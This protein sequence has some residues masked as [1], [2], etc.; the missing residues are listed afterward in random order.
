MTQVQDILP[1]S[2]LQQGLFFHALH[3]E[4]DLYTAQ[5]TLDLDGPLDVP[6]LRAAA[7]RLLERHSNLRAAFWHEDL[8]R[9]VQVIPDSVEPSWRE[10]E[11]ADPAVVAAEERAR[12]FDLAVPPLI[13]FVLVRPEPGRHRLIIT[14]HHILLDGWSTPLLV[15]ELLA[16]YLGVEA[17]P[18]PPYKNYLAWL[19][20]QDRAAAKDAWDRALEGIDEPTLVAP[21]AG[22][23]VTPGKVAT[24]LGA[25][26][27]AALTRLARRRGVTVNTVL[28][29]VWGL[30]LAKLTGREDVV[31]GAVVS[32][33]PPELPGVEHMVG[34]FINTVPVR[35]RL[36]PAEPVGEMLERLQDEQ[37]ELMPHHHLGLTEIQRGILFDTVT[38][39]ENYPFD[40]STA[41]TA[42]GEV[43]LTGFGSTDAHHYP[44]ALAALP[45]DRLT[46]RLDHRPDLFSTAEARRLLDR[47]SLLLTAIVTDPDT[48]VGR[49]GILDVAEHR[50]AVE[51][52]NETGAPVP[53]RT[54]PE[55]FEAAVTRDPEATAL[56]HLG[57][58][59]TYGQLNGRA[60][61]L[62]RLL[63]A[64]HGIGPERLVALRLRRSADLV[65]AALA[66]LKAGG[67]YLPVDLGYPEERVAYMLAD[68]APALVIDADW[69]A[70]VDT[71]GYVESDPG[72]PLV[73]ESPAYVIYTS[74]STGRPKG[75]VVTHAGIA[76][77][78]C[79]QVDRFGITPD[80]RVLHFAS[81]SFDASVMELLMAFAAGAA[82]VIPPSGAYSG[83][84]LADALRDARVTHA[85]I[86][87]AALAGVPEVPLPDLRTL[88]V[89]GDACAPNLVDTWAPGRL[90][91]N[92][93][94]PTEATIAATM[95]APLTAGEIPPI[96]SPVRDARA[97]VLDSWLRPVPAGVEGELYLAGPGLARG[98]LGRAGLTAERFVACP[99][100]GRGGRMYRT[101][102]V[103]RRRGD[104][105]V[106]FVGRVD[107]QV[108]VR[109]FRIEPGEVEAVLARHGSVSRVVVVV[110]EDRPGD[111]RL[112]A[113]VVP[114]EGVSAE[115]VSAEGE[116]AS[117]G[118][119]PVLD[120]GELRRFAGEVLPEFMVPSAVVVLGALPVT[121][122]GKLDRAALP[123]PE[124]ISEP[125][126]GAR[127]V[128][129]E[130]LCGVFAEVLGVER[131]GVEESFF[132]LGGDSLLAMRLV[133]R[134]RSVLGVEVSVRAVFEASTVAGLA[135]WIGG[136]GGGGVR[137]RVVARAEAGVV[138]LSFGQR[139]LWFLNRLG[140]GAGVYNVPVVLRLVGGV[141]AG[142]LGVAL[143][144]VV[145]R[146]ES[147]R[148]VFPEV[149]GV[150]CQRVLDTA[151]VSFEIV[152]VGADTLGPALA[153]EAGRGFDLTVE[154]PLRARLFE[155]DSSTRILLLVLHHIAGDGWSMAPLARDVLAAYAARSRGVAPGFVPLPVQYAD[156]AVWQ[157][158]LLGSESDPGSLVSAQVAF[159]RSR[160]AGL[161]EELALPF[162]RP[163][164]AVASHRGDTVR[165]EVSREVH[166]GLL[167][168]ARE[169]NATVFMVV[170]AGLAALLTR[171]G[172]GSD[173]P[174]GSVVAGRVDEAL[175][176][177][178]GMFVNTLVLRTDTSGN[179][180]FRELVGRVREVDL[181]AYG[182]QDLPFERLVEIVAPARSMARHPLFQVMLAFQNNPV[183]A[184]QL[185]ELSISVEPFTPDTAKF[186]LQL[187]LAERPGG[188]LEGGLE[189]SL[190][191]FDRVTVEE[192]V[193]R[194]GRL[195][196]S[197]VADPGVRLSE[198]DL[199][200]PVEREVILGEW[201]GT[202]TAS[203]PS[204]IVEEFEAQVAA[205][206]DAVAVVCEGVE[207]SYGELD[208]RAGVLAGV[209]V[210]AGVGP[211]GLVVLVVPRS[212]ELVV[213]VVA[214]V[215]AGGGYV[216]VD[217]SYPVERVAQI[218]GDAAPVVAVVVPGT[219]G[220][221]PAG[222]AR[223]VLDG[224]QVVA[225]AGLSGDVP[226]SAL[227]P[228]PVVGG[229]RGV[230][231]GHPAYVIFTS[232]STGRPKGVVVSQGSVTR[233]LASTR[234]W[235]GFGNSDVWV[236]F[237]SYAFDFSVWE[238]WGALL[239]GGRL[240]VV[241]FEVSRSPVEFLELLVE[242][243]VTVLNQTP[244]AFYQLMAAER[245]LG[246]ADLSLR[247][248]IF[249]GEALDG[250]RIAEWHGR[251]IS[252][253]NMYGITETTVHVTYAPL[254]VD[255]AAGLIGVG[256]PDLRLYV[257]DEFLRPVPVGV[258]GELY[259]AGPGLAR[260]YV[261]R[262]GLTAERF[263]ACPF[264]GRGGRMYR[265]GDLVRWGRGGGLEYV[266]RVD[267]QV[268]VRG[269]R[270]ELG[271]VEAVL[272]AHPLV[273]DVAVVV[274][275]DRPG[276]RR[277]VAYVVADVTDTA[278]D[279][280]GGLDV[281]GLRR[282]AGE[283]LPDYMVP[284]AV[285]V[286]EALP[287]TGNGKLDRAALPA[288]SVSGV[289]SG[290]VAGGVLTARE[291]V[292]CALFAEVLGVERVGVDEGFFDL[293][294]DS[295]V[296]I[297][298]VAR[299]RA[300]GVV[301][302]PRDVFRY[303]SVREL[304]AVAVEERQRRGEP[305][306][307]GVGWF[308]ATPIMAWLNDLAGPIG[309]FSQTVVLQVPPGLGLDRLICAVRVV[310]DHHDVLRL[311]VSGGRG[312]RGRS[313]G[314][315]RGGWV[316]APG[317][318]VGGAGGS[319]R[320]GG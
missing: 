18:A 279:L 52:W 264:G 87:P 148:T 4:H 239:S 258:V 218:V 132:E 198:I 139:R 166:R 235:F 160:L 315:G 138:P 178:V 158:E 236:L 277:L 71:S 219:E 171:L 42:L 214:V 296:A 194:F 175:D 30:L 243:G 193:V 124:V 230:L 134:V 136:V 228:V 276:D 137:R 66:V 50:Q 197:V 298:L 320:R 113:Y 297:R 94:G 303:Q 252:L 95:S 185:D 281:G 182:H 169:A 210:A 1:L 145:G 33:R 271:E 282:F 227:T 250:G 93:Y 125:G 109:G 168:L 73:P 3:D 208:A 120:V 204:T 224:S 215:K 287:L 294:G 304:A 147:L 41:G 86:P 143:R 314:G 149:D 260:G 156:Y 176:D 7:A 32:G 307:A 251:G 19:S 35:V 43:R 256:I 97:Y 183:P 201:A 110:R 317:G 105:V 270:I 14:N 58:S 40:P 153:A 81:P 244:S 163:R 6:A 159:W 28:Q 13:R 240:V 257:L 63:V 116:A 34:L 288:P 10:V 305:E 55:L 101:G 229:E 203:A 195:L 80:S 167:K 162:D 99:F 53:R 56:V 112:V 70:G 211:E 75:V 212:V 223:V 126:R 192:M 39:L 285:V 23:P 140:V 222:M 37:A 85:L 237:H 292:L 27:T 309:D 267:Q 51:E 213:A 123:A 48:P 60:N 265:S 144:D 72:V 45:G 247:Y 246:G 184:L 11:G 129:E 46:L 216:P 69:L 241:S 38:V 196:E 155:L 308:P 84:A 242:C 234:E 316:C 151:E 96:G 286:V 177:L 284:S 268:K 205:S 161:P 312:V 135:A 78:A 47:M 245:D 22:A 61:R 157:R 311:R 302:S 319:G 248:V 2:P 114:A 104:G 141:D 283:V 118:A 181:A 88:I 83:A 12:P 127:S 249:G 273:A 274:R 119:G 207:V 65:V 150:A 29:G 62:A 259:V 20:R 54:L 189:F 313:A 202:G 310:L 21:A 67:A 261:G 26:L 191:L 108:K 289:G 280:S 64:E 269:F 16:L 262:A 263:V 180:A 206:P 154:T 90:M 200:G 254:D 31:F 146:H 217:P 102:D 133:G 173:V 131:V 266:G 115:R 272:A 238:L 142:V 130:I 89:G 253:V 170:Q 25:D 76:A 117:V 152:R 291:E 77:L 190:D 107:Q 98:Y 275:E 226:V 209:L 174:I 225:G 5:V 15:T 122:N 221:L 300:A 111:R 8:S 164:P 36:R 278:V 68:A 233:L 293:G 255:S 188:G 17:P 290:Q 79:S 199:L 92:A 299:G 82:L 172:A 231:P 165:L 301:F 186:D 232:G 128:V 59:V 187:T 295:I 106:E 220:V 57:E 179:P 44:L 306:G 121:G 74:G 318:G 9:P 103:V 49:I 100:G 24:E 91:I